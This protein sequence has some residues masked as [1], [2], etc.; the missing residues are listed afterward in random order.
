M[1]TTIAPTPSALKED[2]TS[3]VNLLDR[4]THAE[5]ELAKLQQVLDAQHLDTVRGHMPAY[6]ELQTTI[7]ECEAAIVVIAARN[8]Q[9]FEEKKTV[10]TPVGEVKR[11]TSVSLEIADPSVTI[12]L[13]K[14]AKREADFIKVTEELRLEVLEALADEQLAKLG[15]KRVTKHNFKSGPAGIDLGKAVKQAEKSEKAAAKTAKKAGA[16]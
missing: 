10:A 15:I 6:K 14:A 2:F 8:P 4:L 13:V 1:S 7:G 12:T 3:L 16:S 5:N 9:W 11:T